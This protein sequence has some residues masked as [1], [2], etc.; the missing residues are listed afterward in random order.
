M[1]KHMRENETPD[2][3]KTGFEKLTP[4]ADADIGIYSD[5]LDF[6]LS[7]DEINNI[8]LTGS[9]CSGKSSVM[10]SYERNHPDKK[11]IHISLAH[12]SSLP[13]KPEL[14]S[15]ENNQLEGKVINQLLYQIPSEN[16]PRSNFKIVKGSSW[17]SILKRAFAVLAFIICECH[18][19]FYN[20]WHD[21]AV[22][23]AFLKWLS[24]P[25]WMILSSAVVIFLLFRLIYN[26]I[27]SQKY[28]I[29]KKL[30]I[31][32]NEIELFEK[33]KES[34]FDRYLDEIIYIFEHSYADVIIFEDIDRFDSTEIFERLREINIIINRKL[35]TFPRLRRLGFWKYLK[36]LHDVVR[37]KG[38]SF[39]DLKASQKVGNIK[40]VYMIKDDI[41]VSKDRTKFF[42]FIIPIIPVVDSSNSYDLLIRTL[43][44]HGLIEE[45]D[46]MFLRRIALFVDDMRILKNICNEYK[47][48][49][50]RLGGNKS[51][52]D[53]IF[54]M[55]TYKNIF[56]IDFQALQMNKGYVYKFFEKK[57]FL[58]ERLK[59]HIDKDG[60]IDLS[61]KTILLY[62]SQKKTLSEIDT[63]TLKQILSHLGYKEAKEMLFADTDIQKEYHINADYLDLLDFLL[64]EGYIDEAYSDYTSYFYEE[65]L[66]RNDKVFLRAILGNSSLPYDY[67]L[68]D[69]EHV[70]SYLNEVDYRKNSVLNI[71]L[72]DYLICHSDIYAQAISTVFNLIK[73][74]K[75]TD[76][77]VRYCN[78]QSK[79]M[80][81][82]VKKL[83]DIWPNMLSSI[84]IQSD[85][86]EF[87]KYYSLITVAYCDEK[88]VNTVFEVTKISELIPEYYDFFDKNAANLTK[89]TEEL[90]KHDIKFKKVRP[91]ILH[92]S[93][94][95]AAVFENNLYEFNRA[96]LNSMYRCFASGTNYFSDILF[97]TYSEI[98][99][100]FNAD[101]GVLKS[102]VDENISQFMEIILSQGWEKISDDRKSVIRLLNENNIKQDDK[103][104]YI[105]V[106]SCDEQLD[107]NDIDSID[108]L[109][110]LIHKKLIRQTENNVF[111]YYVRRRLLDEE[112]ISLITEGNPRYN[113]H[114]IKTTHPSYNYFN[115]FITDVINCQSIRGDTFRS[116]VST[117]DVIYDSFQFTDIPEAKIKTM[118]TCRVIVMNYNNLLFM[119]RNYSSSIKTFITAN[120]REYVRV[121][122][123]YRSLYNYDE[124]LH[125]LHTRVHLDIKKRIIRCTPPEQKIS[126]VKKGYTDPLIMYIITGEYFDV[127][128][129]KYLS[130]NY[131]KLSSNIKSCYPDVVKQHV[132]YILKKEIRI[133]KSVFDQIFSF[134]YEG[135]VDLLLSQMSY[136]SEKEIIDALLVL[137]LVD[138]VNVF[139]R[140]KRPKIEITE[141]NGRILDKFVELKIISGYSVSSDGK[142]YTIK[143]GRT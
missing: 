132:N 1:G 15:N 125:L 25:L 67:A 135:S 29:I 110:Y 2:I 11:Y 59:D 62:E 48:Y 57:G 31:S 41:F 130:D 16:I 5:A 137:E 90:K 37:Y 118:I 23:Y 13:D 52:H 56:P 119:R 143:R 32:D 112:L 96:N 22:N 64:S 46:R 17:V 55:I 75:N 58:A 97:P 66:T 141:T 109:P 108:L 8:A 79:G 127:G 122:Q 45:I 10:L 72:V 129:L 34:V 61:I 14:N 60:K 88:V 68:D 102:Y 70:I 18:L 4:T 128:D 111:D 33:D 71:S 9:Y 86:G 6:A 139:Y 84:D 126:V 93:D 74:E 38:Y 123:N 50:E 89:V 27:N 20:Y 30:K 140:K 80:I 113:M 133:P 35:K 115:N 91:D 121:I 106:L 78:V 142:Y 98:C 81:E 117:C 43:S 124:M 95:A 65:S 83:N 12:F 19:I 100:P 114:N 73:V 36:A 116:I 94:F 51:N 24:S 120:S 105:S 87:L 53:Y 103:I 99:S 40:F 134:H 26:L 76:F 82:F 138:L 77:I 49:T 69:A 136:F 63:Y 44:E 107:V 131:D 39:K 28:S 104:T 54:A 47:I 85:L 7:D 101:H 92:F 21:F 3:K 42:D